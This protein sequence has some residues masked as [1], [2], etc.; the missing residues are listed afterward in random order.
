MNQV[1]DSLKSTVTKLMNMAEE[2]NEDLHEEGESDSDVELE[3]DENDDGAY[4]SDSDVELDETPPRGGSAVAL[5]KGGTRKVRSNPQMPPSRE[6]SV[7]DL[8]ATM[9]GLLD[10]DG[11][12]VGDESVVMVPLVR[13]LSK[14]F[15]DTKKDVNDNVIVNATGMGSWE[16][17]TL[18]AAR[19]A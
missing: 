11:N 15:G 13:G 12:P 5:K 9:Q 17:P 2:T 7:E 10:Q 4:E 18:D 6:E 8:E 19:G 1:T 16:I 14:L 3:A